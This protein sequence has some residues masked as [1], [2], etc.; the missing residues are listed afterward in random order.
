MRLTSFVRLLREFLP[1]SLPSH[2]MTDLVVR[3]LLVD[4]QAP[5]P[6]HWCA[7]DAFRTAFMNALSMSFPVGEQ[8]FIDAVRDGQKALPP[9]QQARYAQEVQGFIGQEAT[10]RRLHALYNEHLGPARPASAQDAG[11][12]GRAPRASGHCGL[13]TLHRHPGRLAATSPRGPGR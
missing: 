7:G 13:R 9:E 12:P 1:R 3:R 5:L 4:M 11:R 2:P 8:F 6:R 10:H